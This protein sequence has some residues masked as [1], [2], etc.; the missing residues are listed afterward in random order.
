MTDSQAL[1]CA[2]NLLLSCWLRL[3]LALLV[4]NLEGSRLEL[5]VGLEFFVRNSISRAQGVF[6]ARFSSESITRQDAQ[7]RTVTQLNGTS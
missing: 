7:S 1:S 5:D 2:C 6:A 3:W 4:I